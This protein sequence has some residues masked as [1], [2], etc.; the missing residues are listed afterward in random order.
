MV[1]EKIEFE[2]PSER[3]SAV[4]CVTPGGAIID[5]GSQ[6]VQFS[7]SNRPIP[8]RCGRPLQDECGT[9]RKA[10]RTLSMSRQRPGSIVEP[11]LG[12]AAY[13]SVRRGAIHLQPHV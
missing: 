10:A 9:Q 4:L 11:R 1:A 13:V 8:R 5:A 2:R 3:D 6:T 12:K 7:V